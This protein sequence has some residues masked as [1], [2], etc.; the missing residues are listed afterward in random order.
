MKLRFALLVG[1][2]LAMSGCAQR[3]YRG[4]YILDEDALARITVG[5]T[6]QNQVQAILGSPSSQ[7]TFNQSNNSW[8]YISKETRAVA[9]LA[10][11]TIDQQV[12]AVDFDESGRVK[13]IRR[14]GLQDGREIAFVDRTTETRGRELTILQQLLGNLGRFNNAGNQGN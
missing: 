14:W 4:G 7:S 6:T 11:D 12:L 5:Q 2:G 3:E 13:N 10:P 8:Y 9:F 1:L